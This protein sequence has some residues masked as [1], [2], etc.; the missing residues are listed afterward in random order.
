MG[1]CVVRAATPFSPEAVR[2]LWRT[3]ELARGGSEQGKTE[4]GT[5]CFMVLAV[6]Q[7]RQQGPGEAEG[8]A[9]AGT[10]CGL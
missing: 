8:E 9:G 4:E 7:A 1:R 6:I 3:L 10:R 2:H 5:S